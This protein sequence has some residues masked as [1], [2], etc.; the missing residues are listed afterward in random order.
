MY[1]KT[2]QELTTTDL[3]VY[4]PEISKFEEKLKLRN[5]A[6]STLNNDISCLKIFLGRDLSRIILSQEN[7]LIR[8]N[9]EVKRNVSPGNHSN[10]IALLKEPHTKGTQA[11]PP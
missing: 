9:E 3:T 6:K 5:L 11:G 4:T 10:R 1:P 8:N 7:A 2:R